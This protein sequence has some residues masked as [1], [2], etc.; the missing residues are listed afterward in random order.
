MTRMG[1]ESERYYKSC[2]S[3]GLD[4]TKIVGLIA[5]D[6]KRSV[7]YKYISIESS[8]FYALHSL[9]SESA[10]RTRSYIMTSERYINFQVDAQ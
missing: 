10:R 6:V 3:D 5:C 7:V 1:F 4:G 9:A 8:P 2:C